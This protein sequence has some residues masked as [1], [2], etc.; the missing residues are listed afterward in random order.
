MLKRIISQ[1]FWL[2]LTLIST[3]PRL[4]GA[5]EHGHHQAILGRWDL[6]VEGTDAPYSSWLE[7]TPGAGENL[8]GRFVGRFGSVRPIAKIEF[9]DGNLI[10]SLPP[11]Y[12]KRKD[13]LVFKGRLTGHRLAGTTVGEEGQ[14]LK[15]TGVNA[16]EL[17]PPA[18]PSWGKPMQLFNGRDLTGWR[19]R[20][21]KGKG[22][23]SVEE[24][25][26]TNNVPCVDLIS[27]Q[28]FKD[29]KL[30]LEFKLVEKSNSGVYLRGRY[31][32]QIQ[33]DYGKE[34]E[35][36]N[37]GGL[38]GFLTPTANAAKKAGEWQTYE[39]TLLGRQLTVVLNGQTVIDRQ[40]IPGPTG[41]ALESDE[42]APGPLMLQGDHGKVWFRNVVL[43]P[44]K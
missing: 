6:T 7:V 20:E 31:E 14:T 11:Q 28:K 35:S 34:P 3:Q 41:G 32:A 23:W 13:D 42:G 18:K 21:E 26:L 17:K 43:T 16:P 12:E 33:D 25:A 29:F 15:W 10:F 39:L 40:E 36:H 22:C 4:A 27:E 2:M 37:I 38:Y 5:Q 30:S 19:L 44:A 8:S 9:K 1:S 24:G